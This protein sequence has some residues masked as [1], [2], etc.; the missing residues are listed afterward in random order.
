MSKSTILFSIFIQR[1]IAFFW[2]SDSFS[3]SNFFGLITRPDRLVFSS[4]VAEAAGV[5]GVDGNGATVGVDVAT[6]LIGLA[7]GVLVS[8]LILVFGCFVA[9][10]VLVFNFACLATGAGAGESSPVSG[11]LR[12]A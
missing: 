11:A 1:I 7:T 10:G 4:F 12:L 5:V 6:A 8:V 9:T 2:F 3:S